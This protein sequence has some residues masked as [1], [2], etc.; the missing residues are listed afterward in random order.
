[1][2]IIPIL[3]LLFFAIWL[4]QAAANRQ[5]DLAGPEIPRIRLAAPPAGGSWNYVIPEGYDC[6]EWFEFTQENGLVLELFY[7]CPN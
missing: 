1:M 4:P 3:F 2:R 7:E 5:R 6:G